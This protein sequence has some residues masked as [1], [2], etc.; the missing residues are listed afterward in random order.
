VVSNTGSSAISGWKLGWTWS[1][2]PQITSL[3]NGVLSQSGSSVSVTN[4][5]YNAAIAP[6][7]SVTVGFVANGTSTAPSGLTLNGA[8]C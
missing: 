6:G 7:S 4:A 1:G 5:S 2:S 8:S 3:W